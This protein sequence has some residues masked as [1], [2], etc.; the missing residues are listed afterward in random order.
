MK[1]KPVHNLGPYAH[2]KGGY[3]VAPSSN[4][5]NTTKPTKDQ[6]GNMKAPLIG[7]SVPP[8]NVSK[9]RMKKG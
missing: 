2:P 8:A 4:Q 5:P 7:K 6:T 9:P 3:S 1:H